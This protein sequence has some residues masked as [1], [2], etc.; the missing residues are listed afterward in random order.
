MTSIVRRVCCHRYRQTMGQNIVITMIVIIRMIINSTM[1]INPFTTS[2][3]KIQNHI[4]TTTRGRSTTAN[5]TRQSPS[6][7]KTTSQLDFTFM[8]RMTIRDYQTPAQ[9][10]KSVE[11]D[12]WDEFPMSAFLP[13]TN[14]APIIRRI[15]SE[16]SSPPPPPTTV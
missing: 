1:P 13:R 6:T 4:T 5:L 9:V 11:R 10:V 7:T 16:S 12:T 15:R 2:P 8:P 3:L 14:H